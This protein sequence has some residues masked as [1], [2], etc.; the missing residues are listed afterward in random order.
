MLVTRKGTKKY[1]KKNTKNIRKTTLGQN[2]WLGE[3]NVL[4]DTDTQTQTQ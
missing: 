4:T 3:T 1:K 2:S